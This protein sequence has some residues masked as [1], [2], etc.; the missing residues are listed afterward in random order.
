EVD[1]TRHR[2][3]RGRRASRG[4]DPVREG[5]HPHSNPQRGVLSGAYPLARRKLRQG[6]LLDAHRSAEAA[7]TADVMAELSVLVLSG[8][9]LQLLGTREPEIYGK[10][11]L[12][13]IHATL[14][15]LAKKRGARV[16]CRQSNHEGELVDWLGAAPKKGFSGIL[17]NAGA[18]THT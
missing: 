2:K 17:I 8:P 4:G 13:D 6:A 18:L 9:N 15:D 10:Q 5:D 12:R 1:P 7:R 3:P 11:T 14:K 16:D